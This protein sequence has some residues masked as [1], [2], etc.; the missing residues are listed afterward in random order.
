MALHALPNP[1]QG[2]VARANALRAAEQER[3]RRYADYLDFYNGKQWAKTRPGR[4]NLVVNY[5][6]AIV[7]K[8][9]SYLLGRGINLAVS[10]GAHEGESGG[11]GEGV[12][13]ALTTILSQDEK[14]D[15]ARVAEELLYRVYEENDLEAVDAQGA[16]NG[17][18]L[19]DTVFKVFWGSGVGCQGSGAGFRVLSSGLGQLMT[20]S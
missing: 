6:R 2:S 19:G 17:A 4:T 18:V 3:L 12:K 10:A 7:D 16:I 14:K 8:G 13:S 11:V 9:V 20:Y 5:S 15:A 1:A